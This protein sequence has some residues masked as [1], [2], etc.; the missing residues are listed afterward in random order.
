MPY[1]DLHIAVKE[2]RFIEAGMGS[3]PAGSQVVGS[4]WRYVNR[5]GGPDRRFKDNAE[6]PIVLYEEIELS[7]GSGLREVLQVSRRG[8][9]EEF[10]SAVRRLNT[11]IANG[12]IST[13]GPLEQRPKADQ[14]EVTLT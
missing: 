12:Q 3:V 14:G 1:R 5:N 13:E 2:Q 10:S 9:G 4:T 7:S 8:L 6:L 11:A